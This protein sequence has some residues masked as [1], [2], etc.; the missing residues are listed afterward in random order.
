MG[1]AFWRSNKRAAKA[2]DKPATRP[3]LSQDDDAD[4]RLDPAAGLRARARHRL[5]GA[6][7]L[8]LAVAIVVPMVLDPDP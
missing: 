6:A 1:F 3:P 5:I 8:L 2:G 7:A 4:A